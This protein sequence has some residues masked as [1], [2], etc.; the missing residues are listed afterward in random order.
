METLGARPQRQQTVTQ[1]SLSNHG[2]DEAICGGCGHRFGSC[3][4]CVLSFVSPTRSPRV[5]SSLHA[6]FRPFWMFLTSTSFQASVVNKLLF[7][8]DGP[9]PHC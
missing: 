7:L 4:H 9:T 6:C 8:P 1:Q 3:G 2:R 5:L